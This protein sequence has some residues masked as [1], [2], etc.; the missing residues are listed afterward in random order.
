MNLA[1]LDVANRL[2]AEPKAELNKQP[3][4]PSTSATRSVQEDTAQIPSVHRKQQA[5]SIASRHLQRRSSDKLRGRVSEM[6][7]QLNNMGGQLSSMVNTFAKDPAGSLRGSHQAAQAR[8]KNIFQRHS[9]SLPR[10]PDGPDQ[11]VRETDNAKESSVGML[12]K[13]LANHSDDSLP[14]YALAATPGIYN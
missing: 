11:K 7:G 5:R 14:A 8:L 12:D 2:E 3:V 13:A 1:A 6:G 10:T 4:L 9:A